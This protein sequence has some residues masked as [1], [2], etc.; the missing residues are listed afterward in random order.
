[1]S[2]AHNM[3]MLT[4]GSTD[5]WAVWTWALTWLVWS[6]AVLFVAVRISAARVQ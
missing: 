2:D 3:A 4:F 5:T 6:I 1:M